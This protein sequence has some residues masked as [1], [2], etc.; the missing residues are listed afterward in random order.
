MTT[1]NLL[2]LCLIAEYVVIAMVS[3]YEGNYWRAV[4]WCAASV[5]SF[6]V[7]RMS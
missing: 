5:L 7:M 3:I 2:M 4:Y 6:S 1:S